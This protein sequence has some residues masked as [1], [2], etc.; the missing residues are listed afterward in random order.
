MSEFCQDGAGDIQI[1]TAI[2]TFRNG[3]HHGNNPSKDHAAIFLKCTENGKSE[4]CYF[5]IYSTYV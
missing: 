3:R 4:V 5:Y 1:G 2:A